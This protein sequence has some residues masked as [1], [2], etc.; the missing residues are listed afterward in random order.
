MDGGALG[1]GTAGSEK[2]ASSGSGMKTKRRF[3]DGV[4]FDYGALRVWICEVP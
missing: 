4:K 3:T 1:G 2:G